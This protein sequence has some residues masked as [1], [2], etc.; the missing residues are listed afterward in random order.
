MTPGTFGISPLTKR[1]ALIP[2]EDVEVRRFHLK[3]METIDAHCTFLKSKEYAAEEKVKPSFV[4]QTCKKTS[5]GL[6]AEQVLKNDMFHI[7]LPFP[8][9]LHELLDD[10]ERD[11]NEHIISWLLC[12]SAFKIHKP[13]TFC[14][15][16]MT[17]YFR[18]TKFK[19]FTRQVGS[20]FKCSDQH[21]APCS[22]DRG[23]ILCRLSFTTKAV[24]IRVFQDRRRPCR[25][26]LLTS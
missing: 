8:W 11:S 22:I 20:N 9:K 7:K 4:V 13:D 21:Q 15:S 23:L 25:R 2:M 1:N 24:H 17:K 19:S 18:Q 6:S 5:R 10:V 14:D 26:S 16:I 12:G 3:T